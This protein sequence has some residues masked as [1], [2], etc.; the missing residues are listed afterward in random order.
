MLCFMCVK[1]KCT[2][3]N[4]FIEQILCKE[5]KMKA[6]ISPIE[7]TFLS[8][9]NSNDFS[10]AIE[11]L[12]HVRFT[13]WSRG[14]TF[15]TSVKYICVSVC[16]LCVFLPKERLSCCLTCRCICYITCRT[17]LILSFPLLCL[18]QQN[19]LHHFFCFSYHWRS[20][21]W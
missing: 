8:W 12:L 4:I 6:N 17:A 19:F 2:F 5:V 15:K 7:Q 18:C 1:V 21:N 11:V 3:K 10:P 9:S 14:A 20:L 13:H 16:V